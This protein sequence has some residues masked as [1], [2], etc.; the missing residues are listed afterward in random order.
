MTLTA[1]D[2]LIQRMAAA[3]TIG[4][5]TGAGVS[6][7]SGIA[8][9][10]DPGGLWARFRPEELANIEAFLKNPQLVQD[11]YSHRRA[12]IEDAEPNDGH[13]A[14]VD[15]AGGSATVTIITQNVDGLHQRA[16]STDV[17][18]LH[19]SIFR[20]FCLDCGADAD[21]A[22]AGGDAVRCPSC[23]GLVRPDVVWFGEVLPE[24][25]LARATELARTA[26]VFLSIGT[27]AVVYPAADLPLLARRF[28]AYTAEINVTPSAIAQEMHEVV[29][30]PSGWVLPSLVR[31][32]LD[33]TTGASLDA[34]TA[35][36]GR[37]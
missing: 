33:K 17:V 10:R 6:A 11:W 37:Q 13:R 12:I 9:F 2:T 19:G 7:E 1:T 32:V 25:A 30:G 26:D 8:T 18:E 20:N 31:A 24:N 36:S 5:L 4:V 23:G 28:G 22:L 14:L 34:P 15:L 29:L 16:G 21:P 35:A 3:K 27:S